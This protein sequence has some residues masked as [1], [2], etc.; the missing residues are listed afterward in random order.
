M[1]LR[2]R[3]GALL[4]SRRRIVEAGGD[5]C[6]CGPPPPPCPWYFRATSCPDQECVPAGL[7][8]YIC[9][10]ATC[11]DG[12]PIGM[13]AVV[14]VGAACY[15]VDAA[16]YVECPPPP[17]DGFTC[18]PLGAIVLPDRVVECV[19]GCGDPSCSGVY[20]LEVR[21]CACGAGQGEQACYVVRCTAFAAAAA[22]YGRSCLVFSPIGPADDTCYRVG[23]SSRVLDR[24]PEGCSEVPIDDPDLV[25]V[26]DSCCHCCSELGRYP[27]TPCLYEDRTQL[28]DP[29][30][31]TAYS[32]GDLPLVQA[33]P[34][35]C[36]RDP[37]AR[38]E[39]AYRYA[40]QL[41]FNSPIYRNADWSGWIGRTSAAVVF[42]FRHWQVI[43]GEENIIEE[44]T[45]TLTDSRF[46][47]CHPMSIAYESFPLA[48]SIDFRLPSNKI[49][50]GGSRSF[51]C[52]TYA[53]SHRSEIRH[54]DGQDLFATLESRHEVRI[55]PRSGICA[56][57]CTPSMRVPPGGI[58]PPPPG[59]GLD[60]GGGGG[61]GFA[62]GGCA[63]CGD[64]GGLGEAL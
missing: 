3:D 43:S 27:E 25:Y 2:S 58:D 8:V 17:G 26:Y 63:G 55:Q 37:I 53:H 49:W 6:C 19:P 56:E 5:E 22:L 64:R 61:G 30:S 40:E 41:Q 36:G 1:T 52:R 59:G 18:L 47:G 23:P 13:G 12:T 44:Y 51:E 24:V 32:D 7:N 29:W 60:G 15:R 46:G 21:P 14:R 33:G 62:G 4:I 35:C 34:C 50:L 31:L 45:R 54:N 48:G 42:R 57:D 9:S 39:G 11:V 10:D 16:Y 38:V 28:I 20:W